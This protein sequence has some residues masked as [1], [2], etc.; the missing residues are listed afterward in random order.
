MSIDNQP[1]IGLAIQ[2]A[3]SLLDGVGRH[4][5]T[6]YYRVSYTEFAGAPLS[7]AELCEQA[8]N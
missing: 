5:R 8:V 7:Y 4:T 2:Q 1:Y 6:L 3:T